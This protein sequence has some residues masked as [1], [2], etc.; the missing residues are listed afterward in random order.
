[1]ATC[2]SVTAAS[3]RNPDIGVGM[4]DSAMFGVSQFDLVETGRRVKVFS[5]KTDTLGEMKIELIR[6]FPFTSD[7]QFQGVIVYITAEDR[8]VYYAWV[9]PKLSWGSV[10]LPLFPP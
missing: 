5:G 10:N 4:L 7:L 8:H 9:N 6:R 2:H 3:L 1:M